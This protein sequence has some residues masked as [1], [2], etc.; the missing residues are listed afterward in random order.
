[1][2]AETVTFTLP[3]GTKVTAS[4]DLAKRLGYSE[5][6]SRKAADSKSEK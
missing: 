1:M 2:A 5:P 3:A 6:K 4:V